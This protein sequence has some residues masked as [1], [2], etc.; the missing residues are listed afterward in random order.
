LMKYSF[1]H[2]LKHQAIQKLIREQKQLEDKALRTW[3]QMIKQHKHK[4]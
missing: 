4:Q 1:R 3:K 2:M